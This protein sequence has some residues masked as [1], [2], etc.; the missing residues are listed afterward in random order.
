MTFIKY[1]LLTVLSTTQITGLGY[2]TSAS[3][4][5]SNKNQV[6][7]HKTSAFQQI[8]SLIKLGITQ[9]KHD[10][11]DKALITY[12]TALEV[13]QNNNL[14]EIEAIILNNIGL[15]W[16]SLDEYAKGIEYYEQSLLSF[17]ATG[18][19]PKI[20][21]N[22][23]NLGIVYKKRGIY[24]KAMKYL[25]EAVKLFEKH[26]IKKELAS[27]YNSIA[28]IHGK[29]ENYTM[30]L[31]YH[32]KS[33]NIRKELNY[34][35]GIASSLNNLGNIYK[36][37]DSLF[38]ALE[39]YQKSLT[40]KRKY[41]NP[42]SIATALVNIGKIHLEM[43]DFE[44]AESSFKEGRI[45]IKHTDNQRITALTS[46]ALGELYQK[47]NMYPEAEEQL[48]EALHIGQQI[49]AQHIILKNAQ[50]LQQCFRDQ[51][52]YTHA[53]KYFDLYDRIRDSIFDK[54]KAKIL[55]ELQLNYETQKKEQEIKSLNEIN[56]IQ[57]QLIS[58]RTRLIYLI[59]AG[60]VIFLTLT[61]LT[62]IGFNRAKSAKDQLNILMH[63]R[64]HRAKNN[65]QI[66]SSILNLQSQ[67]LNTIEA[68]NA[69]KGGE[70]RLQTI[71]IL[72]RILYNT[73]NSTN[74][75]M[76]DYL[77]ELCQSLL[78]S[79]NLEESN[80][81][82]KTHFDKITL[83]S[84]H[85]TSI[86]LIVNELVTNA[87]KYAIPNNPTPELDICLINK[88]D[89]LL[90]LCIK[91]NGPGLPADFSLEKTTSFG[92]KLVHSL[93]KQIKGS[94]EI[95]NGIGTC[96]RLSCKIKQAIEKIR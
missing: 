26:E 27:C 40:I 42:E 20:A 32:N 51:K 8:D 88:D 36:S 12:N 87:L 10:N 13:S 71:S 5:N 84:H 94:M 63:E 41:G 57:T 48:L 82:C 55:T 75:Y 60:S 24:E 54:E 73:N 96:F 56:K 15:V 3:K 31:E 70:T 25:I 68:K 85:A 47:L 53:F 19:E 62:F 50:L 78:T 9:W 90:E 22:L 67:Q 66:L 35:I 30:A 89:N 1:I 44:E 61:I 7:D 79:F 23:L 65:L 43:G 52:K 86:G 28:G 80:L 72:D 17:R 16:Y 76:P 74:I 37:M 77:N 18:N 6:T 49:N 38:I 34:H 59:S 64:Q 4:S 46:S 69:I 21:K 45:T 58:N 39:Y 95:K 14:M 93:S 2:S 33:L 91:D 29:Y 92:L 81:Q 83:K 11:F